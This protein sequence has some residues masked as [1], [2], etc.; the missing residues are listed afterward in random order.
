MV[1]EI[2]AEISEVGDTFD[3]NTTKGNV[4]ELVLVEGVNGEDLGLFLTDVQVPGLGD[5]VNPGGEKDLDEFV[6]FTLAIWSHVDLTINGVFD[7]DTFIEVTQG[8][9]NDVGEEQIE[10]SWSEDAAL[11]YTVVCGKRVGDH[12]IGFD[13]GARVGVEFLEQTLELQ[14]EA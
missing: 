7:D 8:E 3:F 5:V 13:G 11:A 6:D 10:E 12:I 2:A 1:G 4:W 14:G 9:A